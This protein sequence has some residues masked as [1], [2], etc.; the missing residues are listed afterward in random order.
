MKPMKIV[1]TLFVAFAALVCAAPANAQRLLGTLYDGTFGPSTLVEI[2]PTTGALIQTIGSVGY[3]VNGMTWDATTSTLYATTSDHD[4]NFPD[5][6][7]TINPA[8]GAGTPVGTGAGQYVNVPACSPS[9][10]LYGWT[11]ESDD[12]VL[13]NKALGT[14]TVISSPV[15]TANEGL[16]FNTAGVLYLVNGGGPIYTINT[17]TGAGT[18]VGSIGQTAHHGSFNPASNLYY[19]LDATPHDGT[20]TRNLLVVNVATPAIVNTIPTV[21]NLFTLAFVGNAVT[22]PATGHAGLLVLI[23]LLAVAGFLALRAR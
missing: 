16:A 21:N 18:L 17:S 8:T 9:G 20:S 19:G 3:M 2:N 5:G 15:G 6:L 4:A 22:I 13:W 11:E 10:A 1:A 12:L 23:A 7:I 14:I